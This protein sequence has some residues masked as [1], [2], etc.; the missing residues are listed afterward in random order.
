MERYPTAENLA[1]A[2]EGT[3]AEII[4]HLGLQNTRAR[5]YISLARAWV[6]TPP[7]KGRRYR[8]LHYPLPGCGKDIKPDE[9]LE[10]EDERLGAWEIA[11]LPTAGPYAIDSWRIFCRDVLRG[12]STGWNGENAVRADHEAEWKRVVP[13]DK[14]LRAYLRWM[15]LRDGWQWDPLSG[16]KVRA[17]A[18]LMERAQEGGIIWEEEVGASSSATSGMISAR[19]V[20]EAVSSEHPQVSETGTVKDEAQSINPL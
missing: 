5:R 20:E 11:H 10:D 1:M 2:D 18:E 19:A 14:E 15:W 16:S 7:A 12:L 9:I 8:K 13:M 6:K 4:R 17:S 3:V